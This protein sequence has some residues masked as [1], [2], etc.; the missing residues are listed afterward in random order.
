MA[1]FLP[2]SVSIPACTS[3]TPRIQTRP[4]SMAHIQN[5]AAMCHQVAPWSEYISNQ[6][7]GGWVLS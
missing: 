4:W 7:A 2:L 5:N 3:K 1:T 6:N